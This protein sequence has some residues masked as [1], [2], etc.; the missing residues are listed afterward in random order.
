[1]PLHGSRIAWVTLGLLAAAGCGGSTTSATPRPSATSQATEV[2]TAGA[3]TLDPAAA[4]CYAKPR[5]H[6]DILVREKDPTL[7]YTAQQLGGN[8]T[9]NYRTN[10]CQDG[11]TFVLSGVSDQPGYCVQVAE[12]SDNPG[13]NPDASPAPRLK[14]VVASKGSAC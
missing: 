8:F 4:A 5:N 2:P 9:Y 1:M 3:S 10:T 13:Y 6:P 7:P 11:I 14:K 12:A